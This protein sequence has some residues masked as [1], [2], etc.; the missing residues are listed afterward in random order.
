MAPGDAARDPHFLIITGLSGAGKTRAIHSLEDLGFYCV[1]NMPPALL[2]KFVDLC[3]QTEGRINRAA[4]VIDVRGGAFFDHMVEALDELDTMGTPYQVIFLEADE[5][6]LVRRFKETRR[7]HPLVSQ[8][9]LADGI[10]QEMRRLEVLRGRAHRIID[11]SNMTPGDLA[12]RLGD[13]YGDA[14]AAGMILTVL[15]FGY[16]HGLPM[17]ADLVFD[18]RFLPNPYYVP[19]LRHLTGLDE[20]VKDYVLKWP[21]THQLVSRLKGLLDFLLPQYVNEG[22]THMI[23]AIGCTGGRHRS[24]V[25]GELLREY[26]RERMPSVTIEHRDVSLPPTDPGGPSAPYSPATP[27]TKPD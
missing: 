11:T 5:A 21:V 20:V 19:T 27:T 17:D 10:L 6:T 18:V 13:W 26:L 8:G 22:K 12:R 1:D 16:K 7:R 2:L 25:I 24:V 23:L 9:R 14:R 3:R 4:V 15:T